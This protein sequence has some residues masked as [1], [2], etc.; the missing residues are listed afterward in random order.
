MVVAKL[1]FFTKKTAV[2]F[3]FL[4]EAHQNSREPQ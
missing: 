3:L 2:L 4:Q 1:A